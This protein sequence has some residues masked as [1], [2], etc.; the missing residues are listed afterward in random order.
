MNILDLYSRVSNIWKKRDQWV[1]YVFMDYQK[2]F[3]T[4]LYR[5]LRL[6]FQAVRGGILSNSY[7][8]ERE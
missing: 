2:A 1:D 4:V 5:R 8:T 7:L 6:D 3:N